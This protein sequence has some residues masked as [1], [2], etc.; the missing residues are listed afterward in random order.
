MFFLYFNHPVFLKLVIWLKSETYIVENVYERRCIAQS[1][2]R[3]FVQI[4]KTIMI[5]YISNHFIKR[6]RNYDHKTT[7][8][9]I[10]KLLPL[11]VHMQ[12]RS[13]TFLLCLELLMDETGMSVFIVVFFVCMWTRTN[14]CVC[15]WR[16]ERQS[17][18]KLVRNI[19]F[20][21]FGWIQACLIFSLVRS[22]ISCYIFLSLD[23]STSS[24]VNACVSVSHLVSFFP[25]NLVLIIF[26]SFCLVHSNT[27]RIF[28]TQN[29]R[30]K[31]RMWKKAV[32]KY[33]YICVEIIFFIY[34]VSIALVRQYAQQT[35][36]N[37]A[38]A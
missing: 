22:L 10:P 34:I 4:T 26:I 1:N 20:Y 5:F 14:T 18:S 25:L 23:F 16:E 24:V 11:T 27:L 36:K 2:W 21:R 33:S 38:Q 28:C 12:C 7:N 6:L 17:S 29:R 32:V 19:F 37:T 35:K 30:L 13:C 3:P 9:A 31:S 15:M 8:T